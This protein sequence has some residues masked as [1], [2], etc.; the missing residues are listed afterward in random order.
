MET[1]YIKSTFPEIQLFM[2]HERWGEC[3]FALEID[4]HPVED[5]T[6]FIPEDLYNEVMNDN[7][8]YDKV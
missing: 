3:I 2:D 4:G 7:N 8:R 5:S 1:K 6:F